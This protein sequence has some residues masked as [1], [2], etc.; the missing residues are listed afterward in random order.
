MDFLVSVGVQET[1]FHFDLSNFSI[2]VVLLLF[3]E[4]EVSYFLDQVPFVLALILLSFEKFY[5]LA[6]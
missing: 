1:L 2:Q 6:G 5:L 4:L 3:V